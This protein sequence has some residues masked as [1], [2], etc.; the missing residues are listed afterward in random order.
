[1]TAIGQLPLE[2]QCPELT[3]RRCRKRTLKAIELWEHLA[4]FAQCCAL[5]VSTD[6]TQ[7][8]SNALPEV[9]KA[10]SDDSSAVAPS[11]KEK[12]SDLALRS[13][14]R[15][16]PPPSGAWFG[17]D[18]AVLEHDPSSI[19]EG[20]RGDC[21]RFTGHGETPT[22]ADSGTFAGLA[23]SVERFILESGLEGIDIVGSSLG[24][25]IALEMAR[26]G[27]VGATVALDP[28]GFWRGWERTYFRMTLAASIRLL[29]GLR[30]YCQGSQSRQR[31]AACFWRSSQQ[32]PGVSTER[33][34]QLICKA[35]PPRKLSTPSCAILRQDPSKMARRPIFLALSSSAGAARI[36]CV[37]RDRPLA[38][39]RPSLPPSCTGFPNA[40]TSR[41]GT[42]RTKP[43]NSSSRRR[44]LARCRLLRRIARLFR[45]AG[46]R[47]CP[48]H[49]AHIKSWPA[50]PQ[51]RQRE[52]RPR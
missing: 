17:R 51:I 36:V 40:V 14:R 20:A 13:L 25:R 22:A 31:C 43:R 45:K 10:Q 38:L 18:V 12:A 34:L 4:G 15:R 48:K 44:T 32:D 19:V 16:A 50:E 21:G 35:W 6:R 7:T 26:R 5:A 41:C 3:H 1:M 52:S 11:E 9:N 2:G 27:R 24:A 37:Y 28:G 47:P 39:R 42:V 23:D 8:Q 49:V 30:P 33:S 46:R 29:R